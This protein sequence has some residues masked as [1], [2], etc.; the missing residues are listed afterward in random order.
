MST[1]LQCVVLSVQDRG[2]GSRKRRKLAPI[3]CANSVGIAITVTM[4]CM[5]TCENGTKNALSA[6]NKASCISSK[7]IT[8]SPPVPRHIL[9]IPTPTS[10]R[11][12]Q[13]LESHF[14]KEHYP[15]Q[16]PA[17]LEKKF[18]V[19]PT[20]MDLQG[21]M[22]DEHGNSM[23]SKDKKGAR[24]VEMNFDFAPSSRGGD[25]AGGGGPPDPPGLSS[26]SHPGAGTLRRTVFGAQL[27]TP[28][29]SSSSGAPSRN[30]PGP[31]SAASAP[32]IDRADTDQVLQYV[33][34]LSFCTYCRLAV[35]HQLSSLSPLRQ[36]ADLTAFLGTLGPSANGIIAVRSA[37]RSWRS[38]ESTVYDMLETIFTVLERNMDKMP[39]VV[40][41][42]V[43]IFEGEKKSELLDA[44]GGLRAQVCRT[45]RSQ[46]H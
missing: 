8:P 44:W 30:I 2:T 5:P 1:F 21:H 22:V 31:S 14:K 13:D 29:A 39:K 40:E 41:R 38:S 33:P 9:I 45:L 7:L 36:Y 24:R 26:S 32:S 34:A 10:F 42:L 35:S 28:S 11:D 15:C 3:P 12:W 17:C 20:S 6:R 23:T 27:T 18:I 46:S 43:P 19:F 4:N 25:R 37:I 16:N